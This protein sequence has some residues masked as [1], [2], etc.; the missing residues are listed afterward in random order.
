MAEG[1]EAKIGE[2]IDYLAPTLKKSRKAPQWPPDAFAIAA[3]LLQHSGAYIRVVETWPPTSGRGQ[4]NRKLLAQKWNR[5]I[6]DLGESWRKSVTRN[7]AAPKAVQEW[8]DIVRNARPLRLAAIC[9]RKNLSAA[10]LQ[11]CAAADEACKGIGIVSIEDLDI[12]NIHASLA[13][14]QKHSLTR[15][16][17]ASRVRVLPKLHT[18]QS[19]IT[20][21]SLTHDLA[22]CRPTDVE[23]KWSKLLADIKEIEKGL[24]VLLV[25]WPKV[26]N[27]PRSTWDKAGFIVP[28]DYLAHVQRFAHRRIAAYPPDFRIK[29]VM[30]E[31][32]AP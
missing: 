32:V 11:I 17:H 8:W 7:H 1:K 28:A 2:V 5:E 23:P 15:E 24:N 20:I 31:G 6:T 10:L 22:L 4:Q 26:V 14:Y 30:N 13:L 19:G 9:T 18:P 16:V 25:P 12:L 21:R 29:V 3:Y 27:S